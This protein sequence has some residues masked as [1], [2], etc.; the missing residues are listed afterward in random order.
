MNFD[1]RFLLRSGQF[2][3][4][5]IAEM[6]SVLGSELSR[7]SIP[8]WIYETTHSANAV[9]IAS[10]VAFIPRIALGFFAG[11]F[12]DRWS[13]KKSLIIAESGQALGTVIVFLAIIFDMPLF[14][15]YAGLFS[16]S[17][18][19]TL[20]YPAI[21]SL[22]VNLVK[23]EDFSK[24]NGLLEI[25]SSASLL[26]APILAG[27]LYPII[28]IE[29]IICIDILSFIFGISVLNFTFFKEKNQNNTKKPHIEGNIW[30]E[31]LD[32]VKFIFNEPGLYSTLII[33]TA[34]NFF[35][36]LSY[37]L[38]TPMI[39]AITKANTKTLGAVLAV[40]GCGQMIGSIWIGL[41][42]GPANKIKG[43]IYGT[44][45]LGI[46]GPLFIGLS[47]NPWWW[48]TGLS[49]TMMLLP[50]ITSSS[51]TIWQIQLPK[52]MIGRAFAIRRTL[53]SLLAPLGF[54]SAG[55]LSEEIFEPILSPP[56]GSGYRACFVVAGIGITIFGMYG[57][58]SPGLRKVEDSLS[59]Y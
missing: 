6:V 5:W 1:F 38:I 23:K 39:L 21:S 22:V 55:F 33:S 48:G 37:V 51:R 41:T 46:F 12:V 7:F 27:V 10:V 59:T 9:T 30:R 29:W 24:A 18:F 54:L 47:N 58:I 17:V 44:I 16:S 15:V 11:T 3:K 56:A 25:T 45:T 36:S 50:V 28:N 2:A 31:T 35:F 13:S 4:I 52:E 20:D 19:S 32:V 40:S 26:F 8:V 34:V 53:S 14:V 42:G 43:F 57:L 49:I